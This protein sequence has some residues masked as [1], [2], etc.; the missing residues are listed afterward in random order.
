MI[1]LYN[2][3]QILLSP[4]LLIYFLLS[5]K[6]RGTLRER[7]GYARLPKLEKAIWVHAVS[8]G[9]LNA[10]IPLIMLLRS[11]AL[12]RKLVLSVTTK[13]AMEVAKKNL[14]QMVDEIIYAPFDFLSVARR[15]ARAIKPKLFFSA[16]TEIWPNL[17]NQ[18]RAVGAT[19]ILFN[20]RITLPKIPHPMWLYVKRYLL[21]LPDIIFVQDD[22]SLQNLMRILPNRKN[23]FITGNTKFDLEVPPISPDRADY[24]KQLF[25]ADSRKLI[26]IAST[27][28]GEETLLSTLLL[29]L[30]AGAPQLRLIFAPRHPRRSREVQEILSKDGRDSV[31]LTDLEHNSPPLGDESALLGEKAIIIDRIGLLSDLYWMAD[32]V[33]LGGSFVPIGGHNVLE[34]ASR[35][36]LV[37]MGPHYA[38]FKTIVESLKSISGIII[39]ESGNL[40]ERLLELLSDP[41]EAQEIGGAARR[42]YESM[43]GA[44]KLILSTLKEYGLL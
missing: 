39:L 4:F 19:R 32:L 12:G 20:G 34:P 36:R 30:P 9:E 41:S 5:P 38:N 25:Q 24:Y 1:L 40:L 31:L 37:M 21:H 33:I 35:G 26:L 14:C 3:F 8:V 44:S 13:E 23:V 42:Y 22:S 15:I 7:F 18:L 43:G 6:L 17:F 27:H 10:S 16:E 29:K 11:E 2:L 28:P